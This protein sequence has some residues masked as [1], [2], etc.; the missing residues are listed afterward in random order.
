MI[1]LFLTDVL[2]FKKY[3]P[4]EL[5]EIVGNRINLDCRVDY[6]DAVN[7]TW[8]VI[9]YSNFLIRSQH[10]QG[11]IILILRTIFQEIK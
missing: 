7:V 2:K 8:Y 3:L 6:S 5:V 10:Q 9:F 11:C 1:T 4:Q